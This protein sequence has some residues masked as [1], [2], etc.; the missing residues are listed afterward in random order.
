[1]LDSFYSNLYQVRNKSKQ[2][3]RTIITTLSHIHPLLSIKG[4]LKEQG[5]EMQTQDKTETC[6]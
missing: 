4:S 6:Y 5:I 3:Q 1:M 2:A